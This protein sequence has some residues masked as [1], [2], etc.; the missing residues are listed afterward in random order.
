MIISNINSY[1]D[2]ELALMVLLNYFG[3]GASRKK[4]LGKR[5]KPVQALVNQICAGTMPS[6]TGEFTYEKLVNAMESIKPDDDDYNE[7]INLI[8]SKIKEAH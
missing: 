5:Y 1:S 8:I 6:G 2:L 7:Y 3:D 4:K